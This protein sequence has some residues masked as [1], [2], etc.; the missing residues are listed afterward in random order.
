MEVH[1]ALGVLS[2]RV[3]RKGSAQIRLVWRGQELVDSE[4]NQWKVGMEKKGL[5]GD[6]RASWA[7][8]PQEGREETQG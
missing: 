2:R 4:D 6:W 7:P 5:P 3:T 8:R 1:G